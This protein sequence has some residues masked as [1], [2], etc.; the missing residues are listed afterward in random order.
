MKQKNGIIYK[1]TSPSGKIYIGKTTVGLEKRKYYHFKRAENNHCKISNAINKYGDLLVWEVLYDNVP[2][3]LLNVTEQWTIAQ[4]DSFN[5]GY[6]G[7][8]G[9]DGIS[10][11]SE[12]IRNKIA[13]SRIGKKASPETRKKLSESRKG[14]K[15]SFYGKTHSE[16]VRIQLS[17]RQLGDKNHNYGKSPS[18]VTRKKLSEAHRGKK[19]TLEHRM[20]ISKAAKNR[21]KR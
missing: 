9:G 5:S 15:N 21:K 7:T 8:L 6:N 17:E 16:E 10:D 3:G 4:Y 18:L 20:N 19:F 13:Q 12:E 2:L 14:N 11:M 1:A